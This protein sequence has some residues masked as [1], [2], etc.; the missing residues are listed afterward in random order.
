MVGVGFDLVSV[1]VRV[2]LKWLRH[3]GPLMSTVVTPTPLDPINTQTQDETWQ[4]QVLS[5][6]QHL[7]ELRQRVVA[8]VVVYALSTGGA[9]WQA[10]A[11]IQ[12][13]KRLAPKTTI[14]VQ[15]TPGEV[16]LSSFKLSMLAG[17]GLALPV[18]LYHTLRF[19]LPG[20]KP[21]EKRLVLPLI[22]LGTGLFAAGIAFGFWVVL[23]LMLTFLLDYGAEVA[24]NQLSIASFLDFCTGFLFGSGI[25]FQLPL[26]LLGTALLGFVTSAQLLKGW[27]IALVGAF[28]L[29]AI[30]TP[31]ADPFSQSVMAGS[32]FG[33]YGV[34]WVLVKAFGR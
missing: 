15:L 17:L 12:A 28:L 5:F 14:F 25:M 27:K 30:V 7:D 32:L 3:K 29:G 26:F 16:F 8:C 9:F 11:I 19:V 2:N 24:Q 6:S 4:A 33:L 21:K 1:C 34:S 18:F 23:P 31:S 10:S 20:M 13:L 22:L